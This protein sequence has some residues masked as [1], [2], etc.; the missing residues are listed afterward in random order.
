MRI[1]RNQPRERG[2]PGATAAPRKESTTGAAQECPSALPTSL[3]IY[4]DS[5]PA[6]PIAA[7]D[8]SR[9]DWRAA[10]SIHWARRPPPPAPAVRCCHGRGTSGGEPSVRREGHLMARYLYVG[11]N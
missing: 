3:A 8:G 11:T 1:L 2:G 9:V 10:G 6:L 5:P 4:V 7:S